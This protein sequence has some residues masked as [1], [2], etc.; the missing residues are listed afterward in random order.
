MP[1]KIRDSWEHV[2]FGDGEA[3]DTRRGQMYVESGAAAKTSII[4]KLL[5]KVVPGRYGPELTHLFVERGVEAHVS[6]ALMA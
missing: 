1:S 5:D 2:V 3:Q 6:L 4:K